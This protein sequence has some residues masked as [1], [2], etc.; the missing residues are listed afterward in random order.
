M[1]DG[2]RKITHIAE[3]DQLDSSLQF[4]AR[5][6]FEFERTGVAEDGTVLGDYT[7]TG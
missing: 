3:L 1:P 7:A 4:E 6:I 5:N 2:T